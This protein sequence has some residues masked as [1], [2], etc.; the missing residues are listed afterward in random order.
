MFIDFIPD[1]VARGYCLLVEF[2][3]RGEGAP[4]RVGQFA[5]GLHHVAI[6]YLSSHG[7]IC[8]WR[9]CWS[10]LQS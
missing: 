7:D 8:V 10:Q 6:A 5:R 2:V 4:L 9:L 1:G 3:R